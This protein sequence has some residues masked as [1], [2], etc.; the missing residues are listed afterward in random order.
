MAAKD[1]VCGSAFCFEKPKFSVNCLIFAVIAVATLMLQVV[2]LR[3]VA[4]SAGG[5]DSVVVGGGRGGPVGSLALRIG[6]EPEGSS[7]SEGCLRITFTKWKQLWEDGG[8]APTD[9]NAMN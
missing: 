9:E 7:S 4:A 2:T 1:I 8:E 6:P 5:S 3:Q